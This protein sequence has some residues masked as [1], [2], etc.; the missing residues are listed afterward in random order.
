MPFKPVPRLRGFSY[1]GGY[2]YFLTLCTIDRRRCFVDRSAVGLVREQLRLAADSHR[3]AVIAYCFMPDHL[4]VLVEGLTPDASLQEFARVFKQRS[5][6]YWRRH[7]GIALW[8]RS[9][10]EHV[11]REDEDTITVARYILANP[12][13]AGLAD[14]VEDYPFSGSMTMALTDLL[15]SVDAG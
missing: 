11:L 15:N 9:Y 4:H 13:R 12:L 7:T 10:F 1:R 6:F 8:Q 2:R 3:V 14:R 5:S